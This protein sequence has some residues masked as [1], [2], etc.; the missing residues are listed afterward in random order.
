MK[1]TWPRAILVVLLGLGLIGG[2][3]G[4]SGLFP[5]AASEGHWGISAAILKLGMKRVVKT[6]SQWIPEEAPDPLSGIIL[7]RILGY[8]PG[9]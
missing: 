6:Q 2:A 8:M 7:A 3:Y 4:L 9:R 5:L 1:L